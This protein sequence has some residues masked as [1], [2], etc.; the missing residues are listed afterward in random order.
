[1]HD[2]H[3]LKEDTGK[4]SVAGRNARI[5]L[6]RIAFAQPSNS[7]VERIAGGEDEFIG[8]SAPVATCST[9]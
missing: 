3:V 6:F 9:R 1:M 8:F 5:W 7:I 4:G 2:S